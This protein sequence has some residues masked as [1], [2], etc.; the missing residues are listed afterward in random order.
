MN[1]QNLPP[2][3]QNP[4]Q[5]QFNQPPQQP[6][7]GSQQLQP[8][9]YGQQPYYQPRPVDPNTAWLELLGF[10]GF[11]G[12]GYLVAGRTN[13]GII[14]LVGY[15]IFTFVGWAIVGV[16]SLAIIGLCLIPVMLG[17][18]IGI[19]IW[20]AITLKNDLE[21]QAGLRP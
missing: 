10:L 1:N 4:N 16:L 18:Q 2:D 19:P 11:L 14:R 5:G 15:M 6:F 17:A 21:R 13:D 3:Q 7:S 12:I 9:G 20:S 8:M